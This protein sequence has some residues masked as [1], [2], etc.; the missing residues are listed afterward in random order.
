MKKI[1]WISV[2]M[3][4]VSSFILSIV[5]TS[6]AQ[7]AP[8][9]VQYNSPREYQRATGKKITKFNEAPMLAE[10]VK[11]GKLPPVEK[12][13]PKEP[14][15]IVPVEEVGQYGGEARALG[16]GDSYGE[17]EAFVGWEGILRVTPEGQVIPNI[18]KSWKITDS[19]KTIYIYLREGIKWSDGHPFTVDD[20]MFWWE[21]VVLNDDLTPVKPEWWRP[22]GQLMKMEKVNDYTF[23]MSFASP[24]PTAIMH[25]AH[26]YG[27]EGRFYLPKHYLIKYHP[28]YTPMDKIMEQAKKEGFDSWYKL[29]LKHSDF[30]SGCG[31]KVDPGAPTL[32]PFMVIKKGLDWLSAERN[33]YYWKIDIAGNQLPYID[34]VF[35]TTA[36]NREV[37]NMKIISGEVDIAQ[38]NTSMAD[39]TLYMENR[40]RGGYRVLLW[41]SL[42]G[43]D[44]CY[45]LNLTYKEDP[46]IREI[47]RDV[48]FRRALSLAINRDEINQ[49][50][51]YGMG[52]PRQTTVV[53]SS[54]YYEE[55]FAKAY[56]EYNPKEAN[57][58]LDEMGL[59]RGPD[60]YRLRPDGKRLELVLEFSEGETPKRATTELVSRYW[61]AIGL[62]IAVKEEP[63]SLV[64][65]KILSNQIQIGL[66]HGD[67]CAFLF[68]TVPYYWVPIRFKGECSWCPGWAQWYNS[69]GKAGEEP[70]KEVKRLL[71]LYERMQ[72]VLSEKERIR[73]GKEIL[74]SNAEN[75][76]TIGTVGLVPHPVVVKNNLRNIPEKGYWGWDLMR[77]NAYH[78]EQFFFK[79]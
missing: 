25:L 13:L 62:K 1:L 35:V 53:P 3:F 79:K 28:K 76:W 24:Y 73:L 23:K 50:L 31:G 6:F 75:L 29:F 22:K 20:I 61:D 77:L 18:A 36:A 4:I 58:L 9:P 43:A 68:P 55:S 42:L 48:R 74:K 5:S 47:F 66:W 67:R 12:R 49:L 65:T 56:V 33:P 40:E 32:R 8:S 15:V 78:P 30:Y 59:K 38:Q 64:E 19:G 16:G 60:G 51:Y 41:Q 45:Q 70:P 37:A 71:T 39:Y 54:P 52:V 57:R 14:I 2:V 44:V 69:G 11:Q 7:K 63:G 34:K 46:V 17:G 27:T 21:D 26:S 72:E 10:L